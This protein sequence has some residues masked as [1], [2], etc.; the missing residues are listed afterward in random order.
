MRALLAIL[1]L[2]SLAGAYAAGRYGRA[3]ADSDL[4]GLASFREA[5]EEWDLLIRSYRFN[6]FLRTLGPDQLEPALEALEAKRDWLAAEEV[7]NFLFA[8]TGFDPRA[9][10]D[11]A[12][13]QNKYFRRTT[14]PAAMYGWGFRDPAAALSALATLEE[15][16]VDKSGEQ[17]IAGWAHSGDVAGASAY[18]AS[19]P[20]GTSRKQYLGA[21]ATALTRD[22]ADAL[23]QWVEAIPATGPGGAGYRRVAFQQAGEA[24]ASVDPAG[25]A[26]W[27]ETH[28]DTDCCAPALNAIAVRWVEQDPEAAMSWLSGISAGNLKEHALEMALER[29]L[30]WDPKSAE[31][32]LIS[33]T[34]SEGLDAAVRILVRRYATGE[35]TRAIGW[36]QRIHDPQTR[37]LVVIGVARGWLLRDRDAATRWLSESELPER[38]RQAI[39]LPPVT[40]IPEGSEPGK[41]GTAGDEAA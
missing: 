16:L 8:W 37:E 1:V 21:L 6:G 7:Q 22:G 27:I 39:L 4:S 33:A 9:A 14:V 18:V 28:L 15:D 10:L 19:Q 23:I 12:L 31:A 35:P 34:P 32:W 2:L 25:A 38:V 13:S 11:W 20:A 30:K 3:T 17:L 24:L 26:E 29:W 5:L 40:G 41:P 36:A